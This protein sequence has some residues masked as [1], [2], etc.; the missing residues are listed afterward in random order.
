MKRALAILAMLML[1]GCALPVHMV[2]NTTHRLTIHNEV[3][4]ATAV[5][6]HTLLTASHCMRGGPVMIDG[7]AIVIT[8]I[9]QDG[10]DHTLIVTPHKFKHRAFMRP[11]PLRAGTKIFYYG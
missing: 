2:R 5:G 10:H 3:C 7:T 8:E 1:A 4:S 6:H 11:R 9:M